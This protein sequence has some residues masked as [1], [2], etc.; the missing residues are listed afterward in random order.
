M[1][2]RL[3]STCYA[4]W[5]PDLHLL[6]QV[7]IHIPTHPRLRDSDRL[8]CVFGNFSSDAF[9]DGGTLV[10]CSLPDPVEIPNTPEQQGSRGHAHK[11]T[12]LKIHTSVYA[13]THASVKLS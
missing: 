11:H 12:S 6:L 7:D 9:F 1:Q 10:T 4:S 5:S 8:R 3:S 2:P 13:I